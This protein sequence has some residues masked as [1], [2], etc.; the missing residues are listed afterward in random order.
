[1]NLRT[2]LVSLH[3]PHAMPNVLIIGAGGIIGSAVSRAFVRRGWV[4]YGLVRNVAA[5]P[6]LELEEIIPIVAQLRDVDEIVQQLPVTVNVIVSSTSV[7]E[8]LEAHF[9]EI[10]QLTRL[11]ARRSLQSGTRTLFLYSSGCKDYGYTSVHGDPTLAPHTEDSSIQPFDLVKP[12]TET[13]LQVLQE[14]DLDPV[15]LRPTNIIGYTASASGMFF[16]QLSELQKSPNATL[17]LRVDRNTI[18]HS[19]H[20]DDCA[21]AY[22]ALAVHEKRQEIA[23]QAFNISSSV[24]DTAETIANALVKEYAIPGG[25]KFVEDGKPQ[26]V[27]EHMLWGYSQWVDSDKIRKVTGWTDKRPNFV[28]GIHV[29]R[30]AYEAAKTI[31]DERAGSIAKLLS[32]VKR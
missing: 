13:A 3:S 14:P 7:L 32:G 1:M 25:V 30:K 23:G 31:G 28:D 24:Y 29:Y 12:R 2:P 21:E 20:T 9:T 11:V 16:D 4:T 10:M 26:S 6:K 15:V 19:T 8:N 5:G 17:E 22:V 18:I 27:V